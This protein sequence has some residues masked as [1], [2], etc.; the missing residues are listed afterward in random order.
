MFEWALA[1]LCRKC[2]R[3]SECQPLEEMNCRR[4]ER[5]QA[6]R[7]AASKTRCVDRDVN[8]RATETPVSRHAKGAGGCKEPIAGN[9]SEQKG[10]EKQCC[11]D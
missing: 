4:A 5:R 6:G 8:E 1:L 7:S 2:Q 3:E 10:D 11:L 9:E